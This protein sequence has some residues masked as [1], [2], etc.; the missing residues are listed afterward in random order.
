MKR[1]AILVV[2]L[3]VFTACTTMPKNTNSNFEYYVL[4]NGI[5]LIVSKTDSSQIVSL[6]ISVKGGN[7]LLTE[8]TS[9]IE[10]ALFNMMTM[11]SKNY[12]YDDIKQAS[13]ETLGSMYASANQLGSTIGLVSIDYYFYELLPILIDGFLNPSFNEQ[14]YTTLMTSLAQSIQYRSEDP[15]TLLSETITKERYKNH[16]YSASSQATIDSV[17]NIT[18]ESMRNHLSEVH[19]A[20]RI[21]IVAV[22]SFEANDILKTLNETIGKLEKKDIA[23]PDIPPASVGGNKIVKEIESAQGSGYAGYTVPAPIPGSIDEIAFRLAADIYSEMLFNLVREHYGS[24]Y[25]IGA[26][27]V[28][29]KAPYGSVR[30]YK[31]SDLENIATYIQEAESLLVQNKLISGKDENGEF[32]FDTIENRLEGYKNTLI[33]SQFYSSQ[34]NAATAGKML[35]SL[36]LFDDAQAHIDFTENVRSTDA[37]AVKNAFNT[38]FVDGEKQWFA[39]TGIGEKELFV[40]E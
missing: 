40:V 27:Y 3:L 25:S 17:E 20:N 35:T 32:L 36:L 14:E 13:Y 15:N 33:N 18:I 38:Y 16:P 7:A 6:Q 4:E 34:T 28:Y 2:T 29:S 23:L 12:T 24:T 8:E 10:S 19:N 9:G 26:S 37:E 22:G 39:V 1:I 5:P 11:G 30:A 31:V 21:S